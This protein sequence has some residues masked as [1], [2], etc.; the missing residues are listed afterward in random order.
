MLKTMLTKCASVCVEVNM[1]T[2]RLDL[3]GDLLWR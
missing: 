3:T 1:K 2:K